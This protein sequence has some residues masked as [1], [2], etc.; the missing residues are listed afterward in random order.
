MA[1][2]WNIY[3]DNGIIH[4]KKAVQKNLFIAIE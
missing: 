2:P 1:K 4:F 3:L